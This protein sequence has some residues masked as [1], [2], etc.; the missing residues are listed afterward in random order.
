MQSMCGQCIH[1]GLSQLA[2]P[3]IENIEEI[4]SAQSIIGGNG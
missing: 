1:H 2:W 3:A 4:S